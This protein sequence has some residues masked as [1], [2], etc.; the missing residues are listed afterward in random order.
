MADLRTILPEEFLSVVVDLGE[1]S[2]G[3][4]IPLAYAGRLVDY[5]ATRNL[6]VLGGEGYVMGDDDWFHTYVVGM[7]NWAF[8]RRRGESHR[9]YVQRSIE[10]SRSVIS[11]IEQDPRAAEIIIEFGVVARDGR[12]FR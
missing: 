5:L 3:A 6:G 2:P 4:G 8:D 12:T 9:K 7:E 11:R 10:G 1:V